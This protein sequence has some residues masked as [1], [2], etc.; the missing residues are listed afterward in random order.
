MMDASKSVTCNLY[1]Q[2]TLVVC[3][4]V[5]GGSIYLIYKEVGE[6]EREREKRL[7]S[8]M[9]SAQG[10]RSMPAKPLVDAG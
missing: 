7:N 6:E 8:K 9:S 1:N 4:C 3:V 10:T 5:Y 2:G